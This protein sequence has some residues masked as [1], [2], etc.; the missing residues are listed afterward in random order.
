M[1]DHDFE[2]CNSVFNIRTTIF[3]LQSTLHPDCDSSGLCANPSNNCAGWEPF[4]KHTYVRTY[5]CVMYMIM[6][7]NL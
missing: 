3:S 2:L 5:V 7:V 6:Y 1:A 4:G